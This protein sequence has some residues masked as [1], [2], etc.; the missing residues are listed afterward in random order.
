MMLEKRRCESVRGDYHEGT[1]LLYC[2]T[3]FF[4]IRYVGDK[5]KFW[6]RHVPLFDWSR[7]M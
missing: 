6:A 2:C 1:V 3:V 4:E 7:R 5:V